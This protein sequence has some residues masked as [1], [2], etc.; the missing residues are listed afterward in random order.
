MTGRAAVPPVVT[1]PVDELVLDAPRARRRPR[2]RPW[3]VF[4][5]A[6]VT[7]FFVVIAAR[8]SLDRTAF[9]LQEL[10]REITTEQ[11]RQ[12]E[13]RLEIARLSEPQRIRRRAVELGMIPADRRVEL[14]VPGL[15]AE[16]SGPRD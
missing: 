16:P 8:I 11:A 15:Q 12:L 1:V 6:A 3:L 7:A 9:E 2:L 10:E 4:T 13:L 14:L 5:L